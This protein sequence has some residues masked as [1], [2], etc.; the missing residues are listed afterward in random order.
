MAATTNASGTARP[1]KLAGS[2]PFRAMAAPGA[3]M[4]IDSA[5]ASQK[6]SS[7]RRPRSWAG[8]ASVVI[9]HLLR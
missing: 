1:T 6:R 9:W 8:S 5:T 4:P 3:M 2:V 7:R